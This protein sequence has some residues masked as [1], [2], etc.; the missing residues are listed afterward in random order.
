M[1]ETTDVVKVS[2]DILVYKGHGEG[3]TK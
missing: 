1:V 3:E 2:K